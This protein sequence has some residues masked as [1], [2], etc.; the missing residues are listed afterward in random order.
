[1]FV[2]ET[3]VK[4]STPASSGNPGCSVSVP[5]GGEALARNVVS[6]YNSLP[7]ILKGIQPSEIY[8]TSS[9]NPQDAQMATSYKMAS[10]D[11]AGTWFATGP[12]AGYTVFWGDGKGVRAPGLGPLAHELAHRLDGDNWSQSSS[13]K[14]LRAIKADDKL[15]ASAQGVKSLVD[16]KTGKELHYYVNTY[17]GGS[18]KA[19][20][21][22]PRQYS[23]DFA[24]AV[25]GYVSQKESFAK[26]FPNRTKY[27]DKLFGN[28][29]Q[30]GKV[31]QNYKCKPGTVDEGFSCPEKPETKS[32]TPI[33]IAGVKPSWQGI[34]KEAR[35]YD[36]FEKYSKAY[37]NDLMH[38]KY[39]HITEDPN[40][41]I[42][43]KKG[44]RDMSSL[45]SGKMDPGHLM[46]TA[47]PEHWLE[48][49]PNRKH[50]AEIDLSDV[51]LKDY[52]PVNRGFGHE[53]NIENPAMAKVVKVW[54]LKNGLAA[55]NRYFK[56]LPQ[57]KE[58]LRDVWEKAHPKEETQPTASKWTKFETGGDVNGPEYMGW[59]KAKDPKTGKTIGSVSYSNWNGETAIQMIEVDPKYQRQGVATA[60]VQKLREDMPDDKVTMLGDYATEAGQA[61]M[62]S[63]DIH[64]GNE[65]ED[66]G[67]EMPFEGV[68]YNPTAKF[69]GRYMNDGKIQIGPSFFDGDIDNKNYVITHELSHGVLAKAGDAYNS[70][71][72]FD[73]ALSALT[74]DAKRIDDR[75]VRVFAFDH[76]S[77]SATGLE[78]SAADTLTERAMDQDHLMMMNPDGGLNDWANSIYKASGISPDKMYA[79]AKSIVFKAIDEGPKEHQ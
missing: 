38:G 31:K 64:P 68:S 2:P 77:E 37:S 72:G 65:K 17:A 78:E 32:N 62:K 45:A 1:M 33:R 73:A 48:N 9:H 40:F 46:V 59:V 70:A 8:F 19:F 60:L 39:W 15:L 12:N 26:V 13:D 79:Q 43:P 69:A 20:E 63:L 36:D 44:P 71:E 53:V 52:W 75:V 56:E 7:T 14:Y 50:I 21:G 22:T 29:K 54:P 5:P 58:E 41:K 51:P 61:L 28:Q 23:E 30:N 18:E 6:M 11:S 25:N 4:I 76:T 10:F 66:L 24:E 16:A 74:V 42:D 55:A 34:A 67:T 3:M 47:V 57:S 35:K 27:L 49:Y